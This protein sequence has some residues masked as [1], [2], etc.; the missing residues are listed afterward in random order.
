MHHAVLHYCISCHRRNSTLWNET[1]CCQSGKLN[2]LQENWD[3][4]T[5]IRK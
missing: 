2:L 3:S 1:I 4:D 5:C